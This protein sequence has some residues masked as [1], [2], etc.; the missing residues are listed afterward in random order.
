M[1]RSLWDSYFGT[2]T[3]AVDWLLCIVCH[4]LV[5]RRVSSVVGAMGRPCVVWVAVSSSLLFDVGAVG[6]SLWVCRCG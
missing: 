3:V 4:D 1:E 2:V 6:V 5:G